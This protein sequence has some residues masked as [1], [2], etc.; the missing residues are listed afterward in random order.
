MAVA[1][2][3]RQLNTLKCT[4]ISEERPSERKIIVKFFRCAHLCSFISHFLS[5]I[6]RFP[7]KL[8]SVPSD[9]VRRTAF[10]CIWNS[11]EHQC[12]LYIP[13]KM[14]KPRQN[15]KNW[16]WLRV[17]DFNVTND[18]VPIANVVYVLFINCHYTAKRIG[19]SE[20]SI[21]CPVNKHDDGMRVR[22]S[23][24]KNKRRVQ[25]HCLLLL[26][27]NLVFVVL[28]TVCLLQRSGQ[29]KVEKDFLNFWKSSTIFYLICI[30][31]ENA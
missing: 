15:R 25:F 7:S 23:N 29:H 24:L 8:H 11:A 3:C 22:E 30:E 20:I 17:N 26:L 31:K 18:I 16:S 5:N 2:S 19:P 13:L 4:L 9:T 10:I 28:F 27:N 1:R 21:R 6:V 14:A 12:E